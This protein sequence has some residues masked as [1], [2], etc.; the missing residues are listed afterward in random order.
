MVSINERCQVTALNAER[1]VLKNY[2]KNENLGKDSPLLIYVSNII[3][4]KQ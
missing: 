2:Y 3:K 1:V 4:K